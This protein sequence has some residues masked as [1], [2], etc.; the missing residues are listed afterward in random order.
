MGIHDPHNPGVV[1]FPV[2]SLRTLPT[3]RTLVFH[4]EQEHLDV[5]TLANDL[6]IGF[7]G[8]FSYDAPIH[9]LP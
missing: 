4:A 6:R 1:T 2:D 3:G 7:Y 9:V 5:V 8:R